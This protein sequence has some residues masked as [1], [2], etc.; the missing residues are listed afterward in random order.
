MKIEIEPFGYTVSGQVHTSLID[1]VIGLE[2]KKLESL[3]IEKPL[4]E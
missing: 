3:I 2:A 4:T 1:I